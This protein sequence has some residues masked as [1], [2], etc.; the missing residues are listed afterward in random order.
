MR[1]PIYLSFLKKG[2]I[3][4]RG[5][6]GFFFSFLE[7]IFIKMRNYKRKTI[8]KYSQEDLN[9]AI[10]RLNNKTM[11]MKEILFKYI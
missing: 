2:K 5:K 6:S 8:K 11:K 1:Y 7:T 10:D 3:F 4:L 9:E